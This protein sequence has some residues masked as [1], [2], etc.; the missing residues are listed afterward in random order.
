M[1]IVLK[2]DRQRDDTMLE[3]VMSNAGDAASLIA[4]PTLI[5]MVGLSVP[6]LAGIPLT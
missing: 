3:F 2:N 6:Y 4:L 5:W 1:Y